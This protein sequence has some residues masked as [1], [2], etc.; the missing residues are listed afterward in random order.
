MIFLL[1]QLNH[2]TLLAMR[3]NLRNDSTLST[4]DKSFINKL[5][6][7][8]INS[9]LDIGT[10]ESKTD[11]LVDLMLRSFG[12]DNWPLQMEYFSLFII[13]IRNHPKLT[14][15]VGGQWITA[16]PEFVVRHSDNIP[17]SVCIVV[18]VM[19]LLYFLSSG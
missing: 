4:T 10:A 5:Y 8:V 11:S 15:D 3:R 16:I 6:G 14:V 9:H 7:V 17:E 19:V 13:T 12:L 18:E 1:P 2:D